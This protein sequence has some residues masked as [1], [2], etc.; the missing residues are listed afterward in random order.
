MNEMNINEKVKCKLSDKE[1]KE[2]KKIMKTIYE[3]S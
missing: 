2:P 1:M 3:F